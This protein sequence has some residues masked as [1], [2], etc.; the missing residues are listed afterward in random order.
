MNQPFAPSV[1]MQWAKKTEVRILPN[2][3]PGLRQDVIRFCRSCDVCQRTV[4][5]CSDKKVL[6]LGSMPVIDTPFKRVV[7]DIVGS[8]TPLREAG[9]QYILTLVGYTTRFPEAVPLKKITTD[10]VG[11]ALLDIY[12]RVGIPEEST[13]RPRNSVP[14]RV[15]AGSV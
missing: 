12:S 3:W 7:V 2:F 11:E 4:R 14:V 1:G 6:G 15:H 13:D 9:H 8:I 5:S 10:A